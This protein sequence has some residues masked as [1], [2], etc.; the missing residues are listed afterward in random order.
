MVQPRRLLRRRGDERIVDQS[1]TDPHNIMR[2]L[3]RLAKKLRTGAHYAPGRSES[4]G[5][6]IGTPN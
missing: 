2:A 5:C 6:A 4:A 1:H 3:D